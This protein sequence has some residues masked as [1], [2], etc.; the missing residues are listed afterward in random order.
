MPVSKSSRGL[1]HRC[2]LALPLHALEVIETL[3]L[4]VEFVAFL[5]GSLGFH[6]GTSVRK[7]GAVKLLEGRRDIGEHGESLLRYFG[8]TAGNDDLLALAANEDGQ[9]ARTDRGNHRRVAGEHAEI[10][11]HAGDVDLIHLAGEREF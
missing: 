7:P 9:D 6:L 1:V 3:D 4:T 5:L 10:A 8:N 2:R 11:F